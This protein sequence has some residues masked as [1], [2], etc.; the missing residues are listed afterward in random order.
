MQVSDINALVAGMIAATLIAD[1]H[2]DLSDEH[3]AKIA[4]ESVKLASLV[5]KEVYSQ[6]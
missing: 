6:H 1:I 3:A 5:L 4:K 2:G